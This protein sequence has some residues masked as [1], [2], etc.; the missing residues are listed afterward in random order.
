LASH[1]ASGWLELFPAGLIMSAP[2]GRIRA[3][4][5]FLPRGKLSLRH[6]NSV[7]RPMTLQNQDRIT[8][9]LERIKRHG[10]ISEYLVSW[11]GRGGRLQPQVTV[12]REATLGSHEIEGELARHLSGLVPSRRIVVLAD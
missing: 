6:C 3:M 9:S 8:R 4:R 2:G 10:L 7:K 11:K 1:P 12:W 5:N